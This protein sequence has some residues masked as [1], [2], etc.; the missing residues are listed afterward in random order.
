MV[1]D[2]HRAPARRFFRFSASAIVQMISS[3]LARVHAEDVIEVQNRRLSR[4]TIVRL[5]YSNPARTPG[6]RKGT[7]VTVFVLVAV[8]ALL[9]GEPAAMTGRE[10]PP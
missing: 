7:V 9:P 8:Q 6:L 5:A 1:R 10:W 3:F 2:A 4:K